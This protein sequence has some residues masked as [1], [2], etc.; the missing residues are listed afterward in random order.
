MGVGIEGLKP[1]NFFRFS[2]KLEMLSLPGL[3]FKRKKK[4]GICKKQILR[5]AFEWA[6][7]QGSLAKLTVAPPA[8]REL[9]P[10]PLVCRC[11]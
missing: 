11:K 8:G 2:I 7:G 4:K 9:W 10:H 6:A 5:F 3:A 1:K